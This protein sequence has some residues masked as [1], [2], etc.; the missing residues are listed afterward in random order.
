MRPP[1]FIHIP[2]T[3]GQAIARSNLVTPV[4]INYMCDKIK[5]I[6][7][8]DPNHILDIRPIAPVF[9]HL[10]YSY[11]DKSVLSRFD[12]IITVVRNPWSRAI[13]LYNYVDSIKHITQKDPW[14]HQDKITFEEFLDRRFKFKMTPSFYR[15][16]PYDQ[17]ACQMDWINDKKVHVIRY[18]HLE[19][20][21]STYFNKKVEIPVFNKG[22][23]K[24]DYRSYY[25]DETAQII[26]DWY[27]I[28]IN[29]WGF[30]FDSGA[31]KNYFNMN[32]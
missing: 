20:D 3:A 22:I 12:S 1:L 29:H 11:I 26:A 17:W 32:G 30:T 24:N 31:T 15:S 19:D 18:E 14:Y 21:L 5:A 27:R 10:P 16:H 8:M 13:S 23:Y 6:E 25:N 2:K 9:K 7:S 4:T 28:D